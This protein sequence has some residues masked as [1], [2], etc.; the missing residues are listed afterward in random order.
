M[1]PEEVRKLKETVSRDHNL[2][3]THLRFLSN[4]LLRE[5]QIKTSEYYEELTDRGLDY[6][7]VTR[8]GFVEWLDEELFPETL[9]MLTTDS[10]IKFCLEIMPHKKRVVWQKLKAEKKVKR[11]WY[12]Q[13]TKNGFTLRP[14]PKTKESER[15]SMI[16]LLCLL[17][18]RA[19]VAFVD[20]ET[21]AKIMSTP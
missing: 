15:E 19:D 18:T 12:K 21:Q 20:K 3:E 4:T 9:A 8:V 13:K 1:S 2:S 11:L 14:N 6:H 16:V 7:R 5:I 17:I 10:E